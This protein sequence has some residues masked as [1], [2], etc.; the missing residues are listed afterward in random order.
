MGQFLEEQGG[1]IYD[2][3][4]CEGPSGT[5]DV[6]NVHIYG[7]YVLHMGSLVDETGI[8]S[9]GDEVICKVDYVRRK[10]IAPN[11]TCTH[12]L[13]YALKAVLGDHID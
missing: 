9:V 3:G 13:N 8:V 11:H 5:F 12:M 2:T 10:F 4:S 7:G 1:Q 6:K